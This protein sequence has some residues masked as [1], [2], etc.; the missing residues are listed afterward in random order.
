MSIT[1]HFD[2][3]DE[4]G[5]NIANANATLLLAALGLEDT[6]L[7]GQ[8]T[9]PEMRQALLLGRNR[10]LERFTREEVIEPRCWQMGL[11]EDQLERYFDGLQMLVDEAAHRGQQFIRWA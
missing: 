7:C 8:A 5:L 2:L 1:F 9:L 10:K 6:E 4:G 3:M 11:A